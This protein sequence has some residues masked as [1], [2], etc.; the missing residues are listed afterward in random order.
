LL[1]QLSNYL[2]KE[3]QFVLTILGSSSA[4]PTSK[5]FPTA[6]L[7]N[8]N[9]RVFLVD[10]GEGTQI[11]LRKYKIRFGKLNHIFISHL[12]GDHIFGLFGLLSSFHLLGRENDLHIYAPGKLKD[13][14][15]FYEKNFAIEQKFRTIVHPLGYK[16]KSLV[17]KDDWIEVFSFPLKH[18]IPTCGY[19]FRE[20]PQDL[21]LKKEA[22][23]T[24]KPGLENILKI[25]KGEN[26]ENP[27]GSVIQNSEL[28]LPAW[29]TRSYAY[30]SDTSY[31][32]SITE[33]IKDTDLLYHEATFSEDD[34]TLAEQTSHSTSAQ[35]AMIAKLSDSKKLLLGHFSSRYKDP[36]LLGKEARKIFAASVIVNDGDKFTVERVRKN[37]HD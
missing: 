20:I 33:I 5:R 35:A 32:P 14:I 11:Q 10:C 19:L 12:H 13:I 6:H 23:D 8:V 24:Y 18:R 7:L 9:E 31:D 26:L 27:D 4:L 25:K 30:C 21:N 34:K 2:K 28:T 3:V 22:I 16:R 17:Y 36:E 1:K 29:K 37:K 15:E